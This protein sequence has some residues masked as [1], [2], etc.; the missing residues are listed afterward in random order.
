MDRRLLQ[1]RPLSRDQVAAILR[2]RAERHLGGGFFAAEAPPAVVAAAA[3]LRP[4]R[5]PM[6]PQQQQEQQD[7]RPPPPPFAAAAAAAPVPVPNLGGQVRVFEAAAVRGAAA[8]AVPLYR[9]VMSY[10]S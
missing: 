4:R 3:A 9:Q 5:P 7:E 1:H 2:Q 8:N 10:H 6:P